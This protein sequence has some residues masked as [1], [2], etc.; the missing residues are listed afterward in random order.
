MAK[1]ANFNMFIRAKTSGTSEIKRLGNSM[2]GVQGKMKNLNSTV[3]GLTFSFKRFIGVVTGSAILV[4]IFG[5]T[6]KLE[7][8]TKSIEVLTGSLEKATKIIKEL[9]AFG[10]V[11][12]FE[13]KDLIDTAK[14][15]SAYG[16]ETEKIVSTVK[17]LADVAGATGSRVNELALA[18]GQIQ[19][20]G[21]LQSQ[22]FKQLQQRGVALGQELRKM[23]N[24]TGQEFQKAMSEGRISAEAVE[25]AIKRLTVAGGKYADGAISQSQTLNGMLSTLLDN[26]TVLAQ[27]IGRILK[28][29]FRWIFESTNAALAG[30]NKM[31]AK[32]IEGSLYRQIGAAN[33][34]IT[35]QGVGGGRQGTNIIKDLL[36]QLQ[37]A[38][39]K[40]SAQLNLDVLER[41]ANTLARVIARNANKDLLPLQGQIQK[42]ITKNLE[43]LK[44]F[45]ELSPAEL[46]IPALTAKTTTGESTKNEEELAKDAAKRAQ[47]IVD[48]YKDL[49]EEQTKLANLEQKRKETFEDL[50]YKAGEISEEKYKTLLFER[51]L[52]K[53]AKDLQITDEARLSSLR[54]LLLTIE[55]NDG[56]LMSWRD[57]VKEGLQNYLDSIKDVAGQMRDA[58][59]NAF[60]SMEDALLDFV[61]TGTLNFRKFAQSIIREMT[62][63][64]IQK[65]IMGP[66][67]SWFGGLFGFEKGGVLPHNSIKKFA[68]G[69]VISQPT[70]FAMGGTGNLGMMSE[71]GQPEAIMPLKRG[72]G[73]R[74][75]VE[76]Q[77]GGTTNIS[78]AVDAS[79]SSV[80]G[81][82]EQARQLG[83]V[84]SLAVQ[85]EL[86][87]QKQPGGLLT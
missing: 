22:D 34:A 28:P 42:L 72:K 66:L 10:N 43:A 54:E 32:G 16:I 5:D 53:T 31:L 74:L 7:T 85:N 58:V 44:G 20:L 12:P 35:F 3:K 1:G 13:S 9:Q 41:S 49:I 23:Y 71:Y 62:R 60:Q 17:R 50:R 83:K 76:A 79:G 73:G 39:S 8:Q 36:P 29:L 86:V 38:T 48:A 26:V 24:M 4:K 15:L 70:M 27:N 67:K 18:Y 65:A 46:K 11:T 57:G 63:I 52:A 51:E 68:R 77:G 25:V 75:G 81:D 14:L 61:L 82:D 21:R 47:E 80:E 33:A 59:G 2:Q 56:K 69:G 55:E 6:A 87:I 84:I 45:T 37:D 64:A 30:I 40:A 78:I 19:S